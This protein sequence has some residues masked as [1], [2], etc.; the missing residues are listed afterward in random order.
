MNTY[1]IDGR[2]LDYKYIKEKLNKMGWSEANVDRDNFITFAY[3]DG[4]REYDKRAYR[5]KYTLK[6]NIKPLVTIRDKWIFY[7]KVMEYFP[8]NTFIPRTWRFNG[9]FQLPETPRKQYYIIRPTRGSTGFG[10]KRIKDSKQLEAAKKYYSGD[11]LRKES[12]GRA[13][14]SIFYKRGNFDLIIS[15]YIMNLLLFKGKSF[16][17]RSYF[18]VSRINGVFATYLLAKSRILT[19]KKKYNLEKITDPL[20]SDT[21]FDTTDRDYMF[22]DDLIK[23]GHDKKN[24]DKVLKGMVDILKKVSVLYKKYTK[25]YV[26]SKDCFVLLGTDFMITHDYDVKLIEINGSSSGFTSKSDK[27]K[28][29]YTKMVFDDIFSQFICPSVLKRRGTSKNFIKVV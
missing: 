8:D 20:V 1:W 15:E 10:I 27:Y 7:Q 24:V 17:L 29:I 3:L 23:D 14:K 28:K 16:H 12:K 2:F 22:P 18:I 26:E 5:K 25:C 11:R 9:S 19:A 6:N 13:D 4:G 21:H